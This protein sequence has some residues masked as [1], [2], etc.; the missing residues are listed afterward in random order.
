VFTKVDGNSETQKTGIF[1]VQ[2]IMT[3]IK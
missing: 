3:Q 2:L 1:T